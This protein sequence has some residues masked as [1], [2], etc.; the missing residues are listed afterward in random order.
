MG[1]N[2]RQ[3]CILGIC[4][5]EDEI[6]K[7]IS[8]AKYRDEPRFDPRTGK[9]THTERILEKYEEYVYEVFNVQ[10]QDLYG[11]QVHGLDTVVD[12]DEV[13]YIG[14]HIGDHFDGG[15]ADL[16]QGSFSLSE[17]DNKAKMIAEKLGVDH[18]DI[19][20]HFIASIG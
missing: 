4:L 10:Y 14:I 19:E 15:R 9:Q 6:K 8:P 3:S 12:N 20:L 16:L 17:T 11:I 7:V 2:Y 13:L 5:E 18:E 1:I